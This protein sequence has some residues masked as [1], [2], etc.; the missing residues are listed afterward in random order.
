MSFVQGTRANV[1]SI[2]ASE[3]VRL[4]DMYCCRGDMSHSDRILVP[5][6]GMAGVAQHLND[7]FVEVDV[8]DI[9]PDVMCL[10]EHVLRRGWT[11]LVGAAGCTYQQWE[12]LHRMRPGITPRRGYLGRICSSAA[13]FERWRDPAGRG[14]FD[15]LREGA[16][17]VETARSKMRNV[18]LLSPCSFEQ[19]RPPR[20]SVV[21]LDMPDD[22]AD[23]DTVFATAHAWASRGV[24]VVV[25]ATQAPDGWECVYG[26]VCQHLY[27]PTMC[28]ASGWG[29]ADTSDNVSSGDELISGSTCA[30]CTQVVLHSDATFVAQCCGT[31]Y[32]AACLSSHITRRRGNGDCP[33]CDSQLWPSDSDESSY[34]PSSEDSDDHLYFEDSDGNDI[35]LT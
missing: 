22:Y 19:H 30:I 17:Y 29:G 3:L 28:T 16:M 21:Y 20:G 24:L 9:D 1:G 4:R 2:I 25:S 27:I 33:S 14:N 5:C 8:C 35:G 10:W 34:L 7:Y 18:N 26:N 13:P 23:M 15:Y 32:H 6:L 31:M 11:P 12:N